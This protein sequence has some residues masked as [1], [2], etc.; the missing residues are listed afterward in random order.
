MNTNK[1]TFGTLAA[2]A[3][4]MSVAMLVS[5]LAVPVSAALECRTSGGNTPPGQNDDK[6]LKEDCK[7]NKDITTSKGKVVPGQNK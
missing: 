3:V 4:A 7:G 6:P 5:S 1:L 2:M